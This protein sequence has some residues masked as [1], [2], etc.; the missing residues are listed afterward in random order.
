MFNIPHQGSAISGRIPVI[1]TEL[2]EAPDEHPGL[3]RAASRQP[4]GRGNFAAT[5]S[6][7]FGS[8]SFAKE[9]AALPAGLSGVAAR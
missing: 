8:R 5:R 7:A 4:R 1:R 3:L 9:T 2:N 6:M